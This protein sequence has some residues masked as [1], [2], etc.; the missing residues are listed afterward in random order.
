MFVLDALLDGFAWIG[1][2]I[3]A[4]LLEYICVLM[5]IFGLVLTFDNLIVDFVVAKFGEITNALT[6]SELNF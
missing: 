4:R 6:I 2:K 1:G 3:G 5:I